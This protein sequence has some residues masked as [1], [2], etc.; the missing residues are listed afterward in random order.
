M[1]DYDM[2]GYEAGSQQPDAATTARMIAAGRAAIGISA[3][4][5]PGPVGRMFLGKRL[6][7]AAGGRAAVRTIGARDLALGIGLLI[8]ERRGRPVRGWLE[9]GVAVDA[10]DAF[11]A[12]FA[13]PGVPL[14]NRVAI[15]LLGGGTAL[16]GANAV[17][18]LS[19]RDP[20]A[21]ID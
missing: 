9:A 6:V 19:E 10:L 3:L 12:I 1:N 4:L 11:V 20:S 14:L 7:E 5:L 13:A 21:I 8:A 18:G 16:A 15:A 2:S 17:S